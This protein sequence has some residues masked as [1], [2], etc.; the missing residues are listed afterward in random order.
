MR[1]ERGGLLANAK[2]LHA[3]GIEVGFVGNHDGAVVIQAGITWQ[4]VK[5]VDTLATQSYGAKDVTALSPHASIF[6]I[7]GQV[8]ETLSPHNSKLVYNLAISE[9]RLEVLLPR[10]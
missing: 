2:F 8:D 4:Y 10:L 6:L 1:S 9:K 7:H 3:E 5:V